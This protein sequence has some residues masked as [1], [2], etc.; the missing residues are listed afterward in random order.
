MY[1][2][3]VSYFLYPS[4]GC[5]LTKLL[6]RCSMLNLNDHHRDSAP[7]LEPWKSNIAQTCVF[8]GPAE[9]LMT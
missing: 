1:A 8:E 4:V 9:G 7:I 5:H 2:I 6:F 3:L